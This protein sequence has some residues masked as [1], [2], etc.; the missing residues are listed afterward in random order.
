MLEGLC[1]KNVG[2]PEHLSASQTRLPKG[3][4]AEGLELLTGQS[5]WTFATGNSRD[6]AKSVFCASLPLAHCAATA[7]V[8]SNR[9]LAG[10]S[11]LDLKD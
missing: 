10:F 1:K 6:F 9:T 4:M 7:K 2:V 3:L 11:T 8:G 5:T